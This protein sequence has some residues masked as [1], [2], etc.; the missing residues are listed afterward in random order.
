MRIDW[1]IGVEIEL[2]APPGSTRLTL[3]QALADSQR[4][5]VRA[6]LHQDSEPSKVPGQP[7]F[8]NLTQGFEAL[9]ATGRLIARCVD[10][11]T[12]QANLNRQ[13][14]PRAGWWRIVSDDE[15]LLRLLALYTDASLGLPE[16]LGALAPLFRGELLT[17]AGACIG[18]STQSA[19]RWRLQH[20]FRVNA[21]VRAK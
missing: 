10:D 11:L 5:S 12:L 17:A 13:A 18:W 8:Y 15:R 6:V 2:M 4:G 20:R 19:R 3:A 9:D 1:K 16:A 7:V 14:S 21:S